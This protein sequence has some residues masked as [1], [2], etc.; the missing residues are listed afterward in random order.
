MN[1]ELLSSRSRF[2]Y[3]IAVLSFFLTACSASD[4]RAENYGSIQYPAPGPIDGREMWVEDDRL[5]SI[6]LRVRNPH[7]RYNSGCGPYSQLV[8]FDKDGLLWGVEVGKNRN[9]KTPYIKSMK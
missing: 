1:K 6:V 8:I 3:Y 7:C 4:I 5:G 2:E 9:Q